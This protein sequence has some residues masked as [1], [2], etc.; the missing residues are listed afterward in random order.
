[1]PT[2]LGNIPGNPVGTTY[3]DRRALSLAGMHPP[4]FAGIYGNQH[5][6]AGSIVHNGAYE[7][8]MDLGTVIYYAKEEHLQM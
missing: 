4:R 3:A 7:D 1:M 5:D 2:R 8:N 6:G